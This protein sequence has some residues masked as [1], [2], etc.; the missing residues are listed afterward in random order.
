MHQLPAGIAA[1]LRYAIAMLMTY[2]VSSDTISAETAEGIATILVTLAVMAYGIIK[3]QKLDN[4]PKV[5]DL[6]RPLVSAP[7]RKAKK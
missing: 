5:S 2:L 3:T 7:K 6:P 1:A 4:E